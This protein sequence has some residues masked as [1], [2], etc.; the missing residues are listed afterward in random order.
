MPAVPFTKRVDGSL[1][2][3]D[4]PKLGSETK[5]RLGWERNMGT[6]LCWV[7]HGET[8]WNAQRR[9]QGREDIPLNSRGRIQAEAVGQYLALSTWHKI[10]ASPLSRAWETAVIISRITGIEGPIRMNDLQERDYGSGS[11]LTSEERAQRFVNGRASDI[12]PMEAMRLRVGRALKD[13]T[14]NYPQQSVVVVA[15]GGTINVVLS[16]LSG[17]EIGTGKTVLANASLSVVAYENKTW[18]IVGFNQRIV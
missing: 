8:D 9:L 11:G 16:L 18:R 3:D 6:T 1:G 2:F 15:H 10:A 17:G 14:Q 7:R 12:E 4:S 13:L 5:Q